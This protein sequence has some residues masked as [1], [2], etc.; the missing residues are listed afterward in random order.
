[1][2]SPTST[3][4]SSTSTSPTTSSTSPTTSSTSPTSTSTSST[5]ISSTTSTSSTTSSTTS[6][7]S[8]STSTS[9]TTSSTSPT[10]S[11]SPTS[12]STGSTSTSTS[13]SSST[14]DSTSVGPNIVISST[15]KNKD[16]DFTHALTI[17]CDTSD[18]E[19]T[20]S[21][22]ASSDFFVALMD[23]SGFYSPNGVVEAQ[24]GLSSG[25]SSIKK[26]KYALVKRSNIFT[27][28][29]LQDIKIVYKDS[30]LQVFVNNSLKAS[31]K[32]SNFSMTSLAMAPFKGTAGVFNPTFSCES[33]SNCEQQESLSITPVL[34]S[35]EAH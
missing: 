3:S 16:Y 13:S 15:K 29:N 1:S 24:F 28:A 27:R 23:D 32:I 35:D 34:D 2:T 8:T 30:Q 26:G 9:L 10:T 33:I 18:F 31:Y 12:T 17:P 14:C 20:A 5:S 7:S 21:I 22:T 25:I 19:F 4:T 11:T 6:T